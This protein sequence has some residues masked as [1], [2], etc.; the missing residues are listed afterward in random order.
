VAF[1]CSG[2]PDDSER[3]PELDLGIDAPRLYPW[4]RTDRREPTEG[5]VKTPRTA[6]RTQMA[7]ITN[8]MAVQTASVDPTADFDGALARVMSGARDVPGW[9]TTYPM[10][11][12]TN[13]P[14]LW[15]KNSV[16]VLW[17]KRDDHELY[18][19][20]ATGKCDWCGRRHTGVMSIFTVMS[21]DDY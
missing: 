3:P 21:P 15:I 4:S 5:G 6:G 19:P 13:E 2:L 12:P 17:I 11:D 16:P 20:D 10:D 9:K 8:K 18:Q 1:V 7:T 14:D